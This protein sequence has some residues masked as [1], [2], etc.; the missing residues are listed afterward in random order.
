MTSNPFDEPASGDMFG[1]EDRHAHLGALLMFEPSEFAQHV[2]TVNTKAGEQSP[3][4]RCTITALE[5]PEPGRVWTDALLWNVTLVNQLKPKIGKMV[6]GRLGQG[7]AK[8]G[9]DA[10]WQILT[11]TEADVAKGVAYLSYRQTQQIAVAAPVQQ[12]APPPAAPQW[13][14]PAQQQQGPPAAAPPWGQQP[15]QPPADP[16][17]VQGQPQPPADQGQSPLPPWQQQQATPP[18]Y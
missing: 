7:V 11:A 13:Q 1:K 17:P 16:W 5:G 2:P 18:P 10:P 8:P 15:Q 9:Q 6:L 4:V 12:Q 3:A 14:A